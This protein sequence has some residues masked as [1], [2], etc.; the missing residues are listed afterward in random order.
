M[1]GAINGNSG[2]VTLAGTTPASIVNVT[3][4]TATMIRGRGDTTPFG[5]TNNYRTSLGTT[6]RLEGTLEGWLDGT[7][8]FDPSDWNDV[9]LATGQTPVNFLL[10]GFDAGAVGTDKL[11]IQFDGFLFK[12]S[13]SVGRGRINSFSASFISTNTTAYP[14]PVIA[15][16]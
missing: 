3:G 14:K 8:K 5:A 16:I 6:S 15:M 7:T 2:S 11:K 13:P 12:W 9:T 10:Y 1:A 4:F